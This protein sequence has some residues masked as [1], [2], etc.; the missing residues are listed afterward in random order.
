[1]KKLIFLDFDGVLHPNF[2]Q[3]REY[4]RRMGYLLDALDGV[5]GSRSSFLR[6]GVSTGLEGVLLQKLPKSLVQLDTGVTPMVEPGRL[7]RY[8]E[9]CAYLK[10]IRRKLDW[11]AL[12][13]AT[14][15]SLNGC[16]EL[17]GCDGRTGIDEA[18]AVRFRGWLNE[19]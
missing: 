17:I 1:M 4:F 11:R 6:V 18:I 14:N 9:I 8:L 5:A 7:Q 3:G 10:S 15:E 2:S 13:D 19:R 12:H 16:A